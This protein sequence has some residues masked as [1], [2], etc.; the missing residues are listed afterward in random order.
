MTRSLFVTQLYEAEIGDEQL[1]AELAR[2]IRTFAEDDE[3]G[4]LWS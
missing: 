2:S 1:L 3:A 4:L